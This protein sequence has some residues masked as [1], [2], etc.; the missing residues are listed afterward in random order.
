MYGFHRWIRGSEGA[1]VDDAGA[2]PYGL[3]VWEEGPIVY[4]PEVDV[5]FMLKVLL[6]IHMS[7]L[8]DCLRT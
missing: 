8:I 6:S 5:I 7:Y 3:Y 1:T 4:P 2:I